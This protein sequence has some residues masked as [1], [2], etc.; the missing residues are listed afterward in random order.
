MEINLKDLSAGM[1]LKVIPVDP[2]SP[3]GSHTVFA[4]EGTSLFRHPAWHDA[5]VSGDITSGTD[6]YVI[7]QDG[8]PKV[9]G[10]NGCT[11]ESLL[12]VAAHNLNA[13]QSNSISA[14]PENEAALDAIKQAVYALNQRTIRLTHEAELNAQPTS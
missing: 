12:L 9:N 13:F 10:V 5:R 11:L 1:G 8:N 3:V 7:L 6:V 14:C 2:P 4:I